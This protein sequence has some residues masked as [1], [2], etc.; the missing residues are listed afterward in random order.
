MTALID[1]FGK[2]RLLSFDRDPDTSAPTVEVAHEA[3]LRAWGRLR[4]WIDTARVDVIAHRRLAS[5]ADEWELGGRDP[6]F[7]LRGTRLAQLETWAGATSLALSAGE[8]GFLAASV[9]ARDAQVAD[10]RERQQREQALERRSTNR[11]RSLV[12]VLTAA[13]LIATSLGVVAISQRWNARAQANIA[14]ARELVAAADA[15][16]TT[17]PERSV[18]LALAAV[19]TSQ[20]DGT[21]LPE[22]VQ[23]LQ[24]AVAANRLLLRLADP[25]TGNV[26]YSPDGRLIA[27]G[28]AVGGTGQNDVLLWDA[29]TGSLLHRLHG[30]RRDIS[31][32]AFDPAGT[33]LVST[34]GDQGAIVWNAATGRM[35]RRIPQLGVSAQFDS[36]GE[37]II[38]ANNGVTQIAVVASGRIVD[39]IQSDVGLCSPSFS[40]DGSTISVG[41]CDN[42]GVEIRD[43]ASDRI[44]RTLGIEDGVGGLGAVFSPDGMRIAAN[45]ESN[46]TLVWDVSTG[47]PITSIAGYQGSAY[48]LAFSPD[49]T[50]VATG[51]TD[52]IARVWDATDG[53]QLQLLAGHQGLVSMVAF[54]PDGSR[55]V[56]GGAD[57][58]ARVWDV[59][60]AAPGLVLGGRT[61][62][63]PIASV[64]FAPDG[65]S[66]LT[67][68]WWGGWIWDLTSTQRVRYVSGAGG[69]GTVAPDG[70][71][72]IAA[73]YLRNVTGAGAW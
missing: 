26:A 45:A 24:S 44:E 60:A 3:L 54:G 57:G 5:E 40:P 18:L 61:Y 33:R 17:D 22:A 73:S 48:G 41:R 36:K 56:T 51:G 70:S 19:E 67:T 27:T 15:N 11:R 49:G 16:L 72:V 38:A 65:G 10:E 37:R 34:S 71:Y 62:Q 47:D 12:A 7:L 23:S 4:G 59:R 39:T 2:H 68:G 25:S 8:R 31:S 52:G 66:L 9:E 6:S 55:L 43:A 1:A 14:Q 30:H 35:I 20:R 58:A 32:V 29:Y 50:T 42:S 21:P 13:A 46:R 53:R 28:G 64:A 69:A 63:T